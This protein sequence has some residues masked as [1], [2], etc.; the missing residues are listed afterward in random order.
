MGCCSSKKDMENFPVF[1]SADDF[2]K[3]TLEEHTVIIFGKNSDQKVTKL[4]E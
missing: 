2:V 1:L 4:I 3:Q